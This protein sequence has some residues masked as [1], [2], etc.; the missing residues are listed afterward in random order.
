MKESFALRDSG[1]TA[2]TQNLSFLPPFGFEALNFALAFSAHKVE[3][4]T[5]SWL[6]CG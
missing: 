6:P 5:D 4:R 3:N 1:K 2:K